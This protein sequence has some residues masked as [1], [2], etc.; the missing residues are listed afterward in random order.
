VPGGQFGH[1][2]GGRGADVVDVEL[3]LRQ[4][5]DEGRESGRVVGHAVILLR[6]LRRG[7]PLGSS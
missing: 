5:R 4:A 1:D 3:G 6:V 7:A 2:P